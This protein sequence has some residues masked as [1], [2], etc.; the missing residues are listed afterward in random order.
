MNIINKLD[1]KSTEYLFGIKPTEFTIPLG[2]QAKLFEE[3]IELGQKLLSKLMEKHYTDRDN[4]RIIAIEKAIFW[5]EQRLLEIS[6]F[7]NH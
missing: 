3:R 7:Q 6:W 4:D 2:V 1:E 5:S